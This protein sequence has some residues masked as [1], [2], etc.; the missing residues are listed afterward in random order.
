MPSPDLSDIAGQTPVS[1]LPPP[2]QYHLR[3]PRTQSSS[4]NSPADIIDVDD[5]TISE[6]EAEGLVSDSAESAES[7]DRPAAKKQKK[8]AIHEDDVSEDEL[9]TTELEL[10]KCI[11][12]HDLGMLIDLH[13]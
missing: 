2:S 5:E 6:P 9:S 13:V 11:Q 12:Y 1:S 7:S 8:G 10:R 4:N 3:H